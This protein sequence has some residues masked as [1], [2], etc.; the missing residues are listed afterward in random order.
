M[1]ADVYCPR[2]RCFPLLF[3]KRID[4]FVDA[5]LYLYCCL[6]LLYLYNLSFLTVTEKYKFYRALSV[7]SSLVYIAKKF[8]IMAYYFLA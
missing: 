1:E 7:F 8:F 2:L 3:F 4:S 5:T 6:N